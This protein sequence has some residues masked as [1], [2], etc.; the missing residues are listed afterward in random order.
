MSGSARASGIQKRGAMTADTDTPPPTPTS[1]SLKG[2]INTNDDPFRCVTCHESMRCVGGGFINFCC[3]KRVCVN[4]RDA[5]KTYDEKT[6]RCLLCNATTA[7]TIGLLKKQAKKGHAWAQV[8]LGTRYVKGEKV[9]H[10]FYDAV[11]WY[12]KAAA[13]GHPGAMLNL[14]VACREGKGCSR[15][16][17]EAKAN[18]QKALICGGDHY[19][20]HILHEL[21]LIGIEYGRSGDRDEAKST[22]SAILEMDVE[23]LATTG[24]LEA[25]YN[26]GCLYYNVGKDYSSALKWFATCVL[27]GGYGFDAVCAMGSCW[28]LKRYAEAKLW[29]SIASS[30]TARHEI[31]DN[32]A[33]HVSH[34][35]QYLRYLR[36]CCKV[37]SAPLDRSNRQLCKGCKAYCYCSRECQKVHW[38]RSEDGH[39]EECK[40]VTELEEKLAAKK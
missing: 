27:Q 39:R 37:C 14:S 4:C 12:R 31:P 34:V 18:A 15:D 40:R 25:Q 6:D 29:L 21:A 32:W 1:V 30:S 28:N 19:E 24:N 38:N 16:L 26:L 35:Q 33:E 8:A 5:G 3:G 11:R 2:I 17:A 23:K 22:L 13:K 9:A 36:Q 7:R 10:S 20:V